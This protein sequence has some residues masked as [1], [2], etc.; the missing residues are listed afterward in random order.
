[1]AE[2]AGE[3]LTREQVEARAHLLYLADL[4]DM[5]I[6]AWNARQAQAHDAAMARKAGA[7]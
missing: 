1:M 7:R 2:D 5:R 4:A 6:R 3:T